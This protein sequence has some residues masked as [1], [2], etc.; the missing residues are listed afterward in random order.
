MLNSGR[1]YL[2]LTLALPSAAL[3]RARARAYRLASAST[4][5]RL[6]LSSCQLYWL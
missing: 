4:G 3:A 1:S 5:C 2:E 6:G